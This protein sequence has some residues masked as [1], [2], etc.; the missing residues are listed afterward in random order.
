MFRRKGPLS[1]ADALDSGAN[2]STAL[3]QT[4]KD[5]ND[6]QDDN[7]DGGEVSQYLS[8]KGTTSWGVFGSMAQFGEESTAWGLQSPR[9]QRE[10]SP[11]RT[12][13]GLLTVP[14]EAFVP[15]TPVGYQGHDYNQ[16]DPQRTPSTPTG[17]AQ[18]HRY[19]SLQFIGDG[20][21]P[22]TERIP[23]TPTRRD[24]IHQGQSFAAQLR[25]GRG[26]DVLHSMDVLDSPGKRRR[27]GMDSDDAN[28]EGYDKRILLDTSAMN[29]P[30]SLA[31]SHL[32]SKFISS[33]STSHHKTRRNIDF[34]V[35][36]D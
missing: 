34:S 33:P 36:N 8:Q 10:T 28:D 30:R 3:I 29:T 25:G 4:A 23:S 15:S 31:Q 7:D 1:K 32:M 12:T 26:G 24:Q 17:R 9:K 16:E 2:S 27:G 19:H 5:I 14:T 35:F 11:S 21:H 6:D 13:A 20:N 22:E 18:L